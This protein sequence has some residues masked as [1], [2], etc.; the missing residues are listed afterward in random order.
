MAE[1]LNLNDEPIRHAGPL[2]P[3]CVEPQASVR[4]VLRLLKEHRR[5][6]LLVC[7][8]GILAGIFT[9]RDA[10]RLL[11]ANGD[12]DDPVE[13]HMT[14]D[15]VTLGEEDSL[16][17]AVLRMSADGYRRVPMVDE[18]GRPVGIVDVAGIV[19]FLAQQFP[20]AVYN[21]PPVPN[22]TTQD[23]EGP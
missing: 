7:R 21:L 1:G 18:E 4:E 14:S 8:E 15:P 23:R 3:L 10:L 17:T 6:A 12:L 22:P 2:E 5:G 11:A 13:R 19:H 16:G 9:E 20:E